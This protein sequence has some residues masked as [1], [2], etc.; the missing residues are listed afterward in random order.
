MTNW[1][2][3]QHLPERIVFVVNDHFMPTDRHQ[4][5]IYGVV[6]HVVHSA[7]LLTAIGVETRILLY[8]RD[9]SIN[10][11][12]I[13]RT[14]IWNTFAAVRL[15]FNFR[16]PKELLVGAFAE[17]LESL[18]DPPVK[19]TKSRPLI[20]F[21]TSALLPYLPSGYGAVIT[22]HSPFV[23][24]V[25][26]VLGSEG[27]RRAFDW[28]HA[29][30]HHLT[31]TQ[32]EGIRALRERKSIVCAETSQLQLDYLRQRQIPDDRICALS[33]PLEDLPKAGDALPLEAEQA[34]LK[35]LARRGEGPIAFTAVSRLDYF[36]NI[37]LF[38]QSC[39]LSLQQGTIS[40]ALI[41]GGSPGDPERSHLRAM[42]PEH[43]QPHV[44]FVPKI[45]RRA[46]IGNLFPRMAGR[47]VFVCS[48]RYDLTPFTPLEAARLDVCT[49]V[50]A[51]RHVGA[52]AFLPPKFQFFPSQIG[53]SD[54]LKRLARADDRQREFAPVAS[55]IRNATSNDAYLRGF[56]MAWARLRA[57]LTPSLYPASATRN[58][59][60]AKT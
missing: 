3:S 16:M 40:G 19:N 6:Q 18:D 23:D 1:D 30:A 51:S 36:K 60:Y 26:A 42:V 28:D 5:Y 53:L 52:S 34:L 13:L 38:V 43:L 7:D 48:S 17:A 22:H 47:G 46:L 21:Q 32:R 54:V 20:Y 8:N 44:I 10:R 56:E 37:E 9:E 50:P 59:Y 29:K 11:P 15:N 35:S 57:T 31:I 27:A 24:D 12:T 4:P 49:L 58:A 41:V 55:A 25:S 2:T 39:C 33:P 45:P 14:T